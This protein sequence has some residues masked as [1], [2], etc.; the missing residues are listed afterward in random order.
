M[1][2]EPESLAKPF[3]QVSDGGSA[4]CTE[5]QHETAKF[6]LRQKPLPLTARCRR[7]RMGPTSSAEHLGSALR[8]SRER[9]QPEREVSNRWAS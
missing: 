6:C 7:A 2:T 3:L 8:S 1:S 4:T 5:V 9:A